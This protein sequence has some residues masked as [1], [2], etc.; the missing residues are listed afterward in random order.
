[1]ANSGRLLP[2]REWWPILRHSG[3]HILPPRPL[4]SPVQSHVFI[5]SIRPIL[6]S[7][8]KGVARRKM[9]RN[10]RG[11]RILQP[12]IEFSARLRKLASG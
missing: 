4:F 6:L 3:L 9:M 7:C 10:P 2:A 5:L 8:H 11:I 12:K 1:M